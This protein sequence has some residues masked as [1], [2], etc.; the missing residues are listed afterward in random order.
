MATKLCI[1][2]P[3]DLVEVVQQIKEDIGISRYFRKCV[4]TYAKDKHHENS[5]KHDTTE[6]EL[7]QRSGSHKEASDQVSIFA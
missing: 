4:Q 3:D 6:A 5:I 2:I 7:H 1:Y